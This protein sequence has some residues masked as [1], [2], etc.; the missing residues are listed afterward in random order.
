M[1]RFQI[2]AHLS[3]VNTL[4]KHNLK[5]NPPCPKESFEMAPVINELITHFAVGVERGSVP[6]SIN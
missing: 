4:P 3:L 5:K 2:E 6:L 1:Q